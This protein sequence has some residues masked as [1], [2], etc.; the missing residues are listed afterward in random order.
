MI[1]L[2]VRVSPLPVACGDGH[3]GEVLSSSWLEGY[4]PL[5]SAS[6]WE[7]LGPVERVVSTAPCTGVLP[8][9]ADTTH[10]RCTGFPT[11]TVL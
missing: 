9:E 5:L 8:K 10:A 6:L 1:V 2:C 4:L 11:F 3:V 7:A